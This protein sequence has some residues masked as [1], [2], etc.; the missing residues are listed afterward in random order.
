MS[1]YNGRRGPNYSSFLHD[2]NVVSPEDQPIDLSTD[3]PD[4]P[5]AIFTTDGHENQDGLTAEFTNTGFSGLDVPIDFN[6]FDVDQPAS[7]ANPTNTST[8]GTDSKMEFPGEFQF[9]D[10]NFSN[11]VLDTSISNLPQ[12]NNFSVAPN[13]TSPSAIS[14]TVP[15][16]DASLGK[17]RKLD[18]E[19]NGQQ[20]IDES[21][22]VAAE[23]DKR[24]RNT[25]ASARFRIKKKQREQ[26]LEKTAKEMTDKVNALEAK[27][28][29]LETENTWLKSLITEK[30]GGKSTTSEIRALLSK[31]EESGTG[32]RS[33]GTRTDGVGTK[34]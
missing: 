17:K 27:I 9:T 2:L 24:R 1:G 31:H 32:E 10:F 34:A 33:S 14:P 25:A 13:F 26:T 18:G 20:A 7:E 12:T 16:F 15:G 3:S 29:Q 21:A 6:T 30:N 22:R 8:S 4:D 19:E 28:Q 11:P 5:F 23:E